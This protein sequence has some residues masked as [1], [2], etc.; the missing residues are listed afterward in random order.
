MADRLL[1]QLGVSVVVE[2]KPGAA[3]RIGYE[4][5]A[6]KLVGAKF[7]GAKLIGAKLLGAKFLGSELHQPRI[8][9]GI[10]QRFKHG[11]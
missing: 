7:V 2:N 8:K 1:Q 4:F 6:S 11:L 3:G 9:C 10:K 5:A